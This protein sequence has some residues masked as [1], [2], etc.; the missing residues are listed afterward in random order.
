MRGAFSPVAVNLLVESFEKAAVDSFNHK[1]KSWF[2]Y[3]DNTF[4]IW[5]HNRTTNK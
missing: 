3:V 1:R 4:V 5:S 2:K